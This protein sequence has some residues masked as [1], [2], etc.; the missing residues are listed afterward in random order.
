MCVPDIC[1]YIYL[2]NTITDCLTKQQPKI[3]AT[4][5]VLAVNC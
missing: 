2:L 1:I 3:E 5:A 4:A